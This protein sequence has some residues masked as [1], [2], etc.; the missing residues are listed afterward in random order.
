MK[1]LLLAAAIAVAA[2]LPQAGCHGGRADC[3]AVGKKA[4][5]FMESR[6]KRDPDRA[7]RRAIAAMIG[8]LKDGIVKR[9][10]ERAWPAPIR[11]CFLAAA[12]LKQANR[13]A[14]ELPGATGDSSAAEKPAAAPAAAAKPAAAH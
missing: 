14:A 8:P 12:T 1:Q 2:V 3:G 6:I 11:R 5:L 10:R 13:C 4:V 9:C 7:A